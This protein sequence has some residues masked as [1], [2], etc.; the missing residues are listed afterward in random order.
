VNPAGSSADPGAVP[1][2]ARLWDLFQS[3]VGGNA[4][5]KA[6]LRAHIP[7]PGRLLEIGCATGNV[8]AAFAGFDY[9]GVDI[10]ADAIEFAR[11]RFRG[12]RD[13]PRF[14]CLD[15]L[16]DALP[17]PHG[18][19]YVLISHTAH[20][21]PDAAMRAMIS[22]SAELLRSGGR[23]VVFDMVRPEPGEPFRK[24]FYYRIDRGEHFRDVPE[25]R[26]LFSDLAEFSAPE[27]HVLETRKLG[28]R[29]ID[30]IVIAAA[31]R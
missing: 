19:D 16:K 7:E 12:Q 11:A 27:I 30:E 20:H 13:P 14:H 8:T 10:D 15:V 31:R 6:A 9:V 4:Q 26:A 29:V 28:V 1:L 24:Q 5:K 18:F 25:F 23:L 21:L 22:R 17:E 3:V 2:R